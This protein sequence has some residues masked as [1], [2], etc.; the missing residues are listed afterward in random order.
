MYSLLFLFVLIYVFVHVVSTRMYNIFDKK[1]CITQD[2]FFFEILRKYLF[3]LM[4][5]YEKI[6]NKAK[7]RLRLP[8]AGPRSSTRPI[9][10]STMQEQD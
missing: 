2:N 8:I 9:P 6:D 5:L 1:N 3:I 10:R 4:Y 7:T